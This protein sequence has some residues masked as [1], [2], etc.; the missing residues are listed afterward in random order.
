MGMIGGKP[1]TQ[2]SVLGSSFQYDKRNYMVAESMKKFALASTEVAYEGPGEQV[3]MVFVSREGEFY[4]ARNDSHWLDQK[5][6]S[7]TIPTC[8]YNTKWK[9]VVVCIIMV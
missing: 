9:T 3:P 4:E 2:I 7:F 1:P 5:H 8:S 6:P